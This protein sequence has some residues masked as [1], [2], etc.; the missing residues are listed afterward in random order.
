MLVSLNI[1]WL[2]WHRPLTNRKIRYRS[3]ICTQSAFI[4]WTYYE[5]R[6]S[7]SWDIRL[8]TPV[9]WPCRT[10]RSKMS[11][12]NSEVTGPNF[13]KF[14]TI[15]TVS[16]NNTAVAHYNFN[17]HQLIL[18]IFGIDATE[19]ICYR[20]MICCPPILTNVF[21]LPWETWTKKLRL[22]SH[23]SPQKRHCFGLLYLRLLSTNFNNLCCR[24]YLRCLCCHKP[25]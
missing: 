7:I 19:R 2:P 22:F 3:I 21:A 18:V 10:R 23:S 17:A 15:Y 12:V 14:L 5:N 25:I 13:T 9:F 16:K 4:R 6:S 11:S 24:Y 1:I 20:T 8:N